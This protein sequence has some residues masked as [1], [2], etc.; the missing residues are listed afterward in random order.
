MGVVPAHPQ[1]RRSGAVER[2]D[3]DEPGQNQHRVTVA[4]LDEREQWRRR[5]GTRLNSYSDSHSSASALQR[6][7]VDRTSLPPRCIYP[8]APAGDGESIQAANH[9]QEL[10]TGGGDGVF[11]GRHGGSFDAG[12]ARA[13]RQRRRVRSTARSGRAAGP[14]AGVRV[15][16]FCWMGV[17]SVA[18][19]LLADFGAEVIK[20]EDRIRI[21]TPRRCRSTR[22]SRRAT[23][24]RRS[25]TPTRT[26]AG[27]STTTAATS[28]ASRSTC[29]PP[30]GRDL[31]ERLIAASSVVSENFAPGVME[32]WG[33]T[34]E[35]LQRAVARA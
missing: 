19:R 24:A 29:A 9:H 23:S 1:Q 32:R 27:C 13:V 2:S 18:T 16:D 6:T 25:S 30:K 33:L 22:T 31:A 14:L 4:G 28:S 15:A 3:A 34:Y 8:T 7:A 5:D 11:A 21:D 12:A 20:I 10:L 17:G 35:R 26:R